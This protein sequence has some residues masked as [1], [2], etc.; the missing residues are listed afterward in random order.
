GEQERVPQRRVGHR[1]RC[2]SGENQREL[3]DHAALQL[4]RADGL[5]ALRGAVDQGLPVVLQEGE[6]AVTMAYAITQTCCN[7]ASC[8]SVCPVNCIHPAPG[9]PDFGHT[10][11]LY[12]GPHTCIDCGACA[13]ACPVDAVL[14]VDMLTGPLENYAEIK[15]RKST[16]L[17]SSHV[18]ISYAVFC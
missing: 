9:E 2:A 5:P 8:V 16:R 17:N 3:Q 6:S 10:D 18:S 4:R 15:D 1:T 14:P 12:I 7:D 13:D 11:T